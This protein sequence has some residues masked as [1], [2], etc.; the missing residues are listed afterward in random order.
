MKIWPKT[1]MEPDVL[2]QR[3]LALSA[4]DIL[5][6]SE[7]WLRR[8]TFDPKWD[9]ETAVA[10]IRNGAGDDVYIVFA[11]EGV[12]IKGFDHESEMSPH[13]RDDYEVWPGIYDQAPAPLIARI[14][15]DSMSREDVTFC[16]W[17]EAGDA[18][19][20]TGTVD[21]PEG[22]D[23]GSDFL[24]GMIYH[25]AVDYVEWA[26]DYYEMDVATDVVEHLFAGHMLT[27]DMVEKVVSGDHAENAFKELQSLELIRQSESTS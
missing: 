22:L 18:S 24:L 15:A 20:K 3:L 12:V 26:Q 9:E 16:L 5:L 7:D 6:C 1:F 2:K 13:A 19:W 25:S 10:C 23:D 14:D 4:M 17:R 8:Y 27:K 11:P 21:N